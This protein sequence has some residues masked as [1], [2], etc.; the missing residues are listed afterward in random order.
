MAI[1]YGEFQYKNATYTLD[2]FC[3]KP[4]S[5]KGCLVTSP[6]QYW[7]Q[8]LNKLLEDPDVKLTSQCIPPPD[9]N[10]RACFDNI[11]VPVM[12]SAIFG[13]MGCIKNGTSTCAACSVTAAGF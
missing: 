5:G 2:N 6:I 12:P 11:G 10:S 4:I 9:G 7:K 13:K 8:D 3:F 1:Q